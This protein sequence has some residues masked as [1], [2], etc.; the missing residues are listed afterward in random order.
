MARHL[1]VTN[2]FPPKLGGIQTYLWELWRRLPADEVTVLTTPQAG[3]AAW[4]ATQ[5][6]RIERTSEGLLL[7]TANLASRIRTLAA[8]VDAKLVVLD[9]ALPVGRLGPSLGMPYGVVVHGAEIAVPGR[10]WPG[11]PMLRRVLRGA[12]LVVAAG[13]YP[14]AE[15]EHAARRTLPTVAVPPGVDTARFHPLSEDERAATRERFGL[16]RRGLLVTS[17]SRLVPRKGMDV[18]IRTAH[19]IARS[20]PGLVVAI[21]GAGRDRRRLEQ[22]A[23]GGP[24]DVRFLGKIDDADVPDFQGCGDV[25]AMLCRNRWLGLEQEGFG[26]VFLEAAACAVPQLAGASG[27]AR[28]AVAHGVSGFVVDPPDDTSA[29]AGFLDLLLRDPTLRR[30]MGA[31]A[32]ER[33]VHD[34]SYDL[35]AERLAVA[36]DAAAGSARRA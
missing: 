31:H 20:H 25:F 33:A 13:A 18:L 4:D 26:I 5:P 1:L 35:L 24:A 27:G 12:D 21:A 17:I 32:R 9:P 6:Y 3:D 14:A 28:D 23:A 7:P 19:L 34:F 11:R 22:L 8:A 16:P 29:V 2:D 36:I 30:T 10:T 15:A